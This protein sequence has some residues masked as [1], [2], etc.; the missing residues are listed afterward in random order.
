MKNSVSTNLLILDEVFDGSL[1]AI[2]ADEVMAKLL[3]KQSEHFNGEVRDTQQDNTNVFVISHKVDLIDK[4]NET[5][6]FEKVRGFSKM[7]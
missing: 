4:F 5:I 2:G 3:F 1:D 6:K 7:V